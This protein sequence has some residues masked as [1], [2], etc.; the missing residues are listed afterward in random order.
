MQLVFL[1]G[2]ESGPH[3]AKFQALKKHFGA[4]ISP[5][6]SGI[7]DPWQ[8]LQIIRET[9]AEQPG[10]FLLI[11]S[12][13]GGLMA[14]LLQREIPRQVA[15]MLL[16]APALHRPAGEGLTSAGLPPSLIIHGRQD[17]VVPIEASRNF[18]LPLLEV[19]DD[20][21]LRDSLPLIIAETEKLKQILE[22]E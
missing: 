12:S 20:H 15:G 16:C 11:G 13:M 1:H 3:G 5:D 6:C 14:L 2:L 10:P 4:V 21:S 7:S 22:Q 9:L 18:G 17:D 8:R 19:D